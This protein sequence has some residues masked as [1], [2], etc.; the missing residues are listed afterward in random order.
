MLCLFLLFQI[1]TK[2]SGFIR[3]YVHVPKQETPKRHNCL[4]NM[5]KKNQKMSKKKNKKKRIGHRHNC[6]CTLTNAPT[7]AWG[8]DLLA[9]T[10]K[11][12]S[13]FQSDNYKKS[14]SLRPSGGD[15][16]PVF[17]IAG[18]LVIVVTL[19]AGSRPAPSL[20]RTPA[21]AFLPALPCW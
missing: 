3:S 15:D 8:G 5:Y 12:V 20:G 10:L 11:S 19:P 18:C 6:D 9:N 17:I 1:K 7:C 14:S 21:S 16:Q 4:Y 2:T 13:V